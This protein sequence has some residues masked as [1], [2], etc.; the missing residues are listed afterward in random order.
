MFCGNHQFKEGV[1][2]GKKKRKKIKYDLVKT[3]SPITFPLVYE[4][5]IRPLYIKACQGSHHLWDKIANFDEFKDNEELREEF[6]RSANQGMMSAQDDIVA[7]VQSEEKLDYPKELLLRGIA[8]AIAWQLLGHQLAHARHFF[9]YISQPDLY[10]S[11]FESVVFASK[12]FIQE[13]QNAVSLISDLTSFIQVGDLLIYEPGSGLTIAEVKEGAMNA[14]I[15]NFMKFYMQS[16]CDKAL[17][18]FVNQE[19]EK[20]VKQMQRMS[21]QAS[22][23]AHVTSVLRS[24]KSVDPDTN[25]EINIPA[26]FFPI[27]T[28]DERLVNTLEQANT[29]GWAIDVIDN[30]LFLGIYASE[31]A[32]SKGHIIFNTWFDG[33]G[34]SPDC[35]RA[36]LIDCMKLP[37]ALPIFSR[38]IP[39]EYKFDIL[40][41]RKQVC[42]GICIESLLNECKKSGLSTRFAT[43]KERGRLDKTGNRPYKYK[44]NVVFI[45]NG[46]TELPLMDGVFLRIMF[47]GQSPV[48]IIKTL[49]DST[50]EYT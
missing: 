20:T 39:D 36:L 45:S 37:L 25:Q 15:G 3:L 12:E 40:F 18:D 41:G 49:L 8:D 33:M 34:G 6:Y 43:N 24:G 50:E 48:S 1:K 7:I 21:R 14:K 22:R 9:K 28:W 31:D 11:N 2:L 46:R 44:G 26:P 27:K 23:M 47:H 5:L 17:Y 4:E 42:M 10:N 35:P 32:Y 30:C 29:K 38:D 19:G 13:K 16:Q